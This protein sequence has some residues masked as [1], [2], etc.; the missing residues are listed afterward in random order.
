MLLS[1]TCALC[2]TNPEAA[3]ISSGNGQGYLTKPFSKYYDIKEISNKDLIDIEKLSKYDLL[4]IESNT[5]PVD[6]FYT[7]D[8]FLKQGKDIVAINAPMWQNKLIMNEAGAFEDLDDWQR[9]SVLN[10]ADNVIIN[11]YENYDFSKWER[12]CSYMDGETEL[13]VTP[14]SYFGKYSLNVDMKNFWGFDTQKIDDFEEPFKNGATVTEIVA[15]T[16]DSGNPQISIEWI[17]KDGSRWIAVVALTK[18]WQRIVLVPED[19]KYWQSNSERGFYGD[20]FNPA[21][22]ESISI[23]VANTHTI[24]VQRGPRSFQ[25]AEIG[26]SVFSEKQKMLRI[27][28]TRLYAYD[29]LYPDYKFFNSIDFAT[30]K[31]N[32]EQVVIDE[33]LKIAT[34]KSLNVMVQRPAGR[35]FDRGRTWRYINLLEAYA[36][37]GEFR[38]P[39]ASMI[40]NDS[41]SDYKGSIWTSFAVTDYDWYK[42]DSVQK[43]L[44][45]TARAMRQKIFILDAGTDNFTYFDDQKIVLG[46]NVI[47]PKSQNFSVKIDVTKNGKVV[48][49]FESNKVRDFKEIWDN[50]DIYDGAVVNTRLYVNGEMVDN[51]SQNVRIWKPKEKKEFVE[52]K[53]GKFYLNGKVWQAHGINYMPSSGSAAEEFS[54][55]SDYFQK[56]S[57][58]PEI[59]KRDLEKL[60]SL[61]FNAISVFLF[62]DYMNDQNLLDLLCIMD[63]LGMKADLSLRPGTPMDIVWQFA[64]PMIKYYRLWDNDV[65]YAYDLAWEPFFGGSIHRQ[66]LDKDW[67]KWVINQY[68]SIEN[69]ES[70]W[71]CKINRNENGDVTGI[72]DFQM[73]DVNEVEFMKLAY[74]RF[75]DGLL[76]SKYNEARMKVLE[77]DPNHAVSFRMLDASSPD[78]GEGW[79]NY[80]F[81]YL[82]N[83]VDIFAPEA[84]SRTRNSG[85]IKPGIFMKEYA[86][87]SDPTKPVQWKE[88]GYDLWDGTESRSTEEN[89]KK[90]VSGYE[91]FYKMMIDSKV[92]GIYFWVSCPGYRVDEKSDYGIF[93]VDYSDREITKVIRKYADEFMNANNFSFQKEEVPLKMEIDTDYR[94]VV[95]PY[96]KISEDFWKLWDNG[97]RP[98]LTSQ[99][100]EENSDTISLVNLSGKDKGIGPKRDID[101]GFDF[102]KIDEKRIFPDA[103][104]SEL[105]GIYNIHLR[106]RNLKET[107]L[108]G[109]GKNKISVVIKTDGKEIARK[110]LEVDL[111][112]TETFDMIINETPLKQGMY[113]ISFEV[114]NVRFGDVFAFEIL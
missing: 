45:N 47:N 31:P 16:D 14:D 92:S 97:Y 66:Y 10:P 11:F 78:F 46:A 73:V 51:L 39:V 88:M 102:I 99:M 25:I 104:I 24:S 100:T 114:G 28:L 75:L 59:I 76:Y 101:A 53:D 5:L 41:N 89:M 27:D 71:G 103:S 50:R 21:N 85:K 94:S 90:A 3:L 79:F 32:T 80:D 95:T 33:N 43:V 6:A 8:A 113:T 44:E 67:E 1:G 96:N 105:N 30:I 56:K 110:N 22:A 40:I 26:T 107:V 52:I 48:D 108:L 9:R 61:G 60:K 109:N 74:R 20:K 42:Q 13:S 15:K 112:K 19:F 82:A 34:P 72:S 106:I 81:D 36:S 98:V 38:G 49:S 4:I 70:D 91:E 29:N 83:S 2:A 84:Y 63:E 58:D 54:F 35:G 37:D 55:F 111:N 57:Y 68:G 18:S 86:T 62:Y 93:N 65:V 7:I 23:G 12:G 69:A 87:W 64:E 17:E 77:I